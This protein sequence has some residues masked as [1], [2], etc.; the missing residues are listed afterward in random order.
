M[1][2][3]WEGIIR[4]P[5]HKLEC[6]SSIPWLKKFWVPSAWPGQ[7]AAARGRCW[8]NVTED[9]SMMNDARLS[10]QE[11]LTPEKRILCWEIKT[12]VKI[13]RWTCHSSIKRRRVSFNI[14]TNPRI[15]PAG[16]DPYDNHSPVFINP[17]PFQQVPSPGVVRQSAPPPSPPSDWSPSLH[18]R[19]QRLLDWSLSS[20]SDGT[21]SLFPAM[22]QVTITWKTFPEVREWN[23]TLFISHSHDLSQ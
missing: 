4:D 22:S 8:S 19:V 6:A 18:S 2:G 23:H 16:P 14:R 12:W 15:F 10:H 7:A 1:G 20:D 3:M 21:Q 13:C 11:S 9:R 17:L 5:A